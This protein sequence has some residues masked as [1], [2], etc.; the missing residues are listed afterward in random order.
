MDGQTPSYNLRKKLEIEPYVLEPPLRELERLLYKMT[1]EI[2]EET[3]MDKA[4][5]AY[6]G[7]GIGYM[8]DINVTKGTIFY[9]DEN[10]P[11][12]GVI[13]SCEIMGNPVLPNKIICYNEDENMKYEVLNPHLK[14]I[15]ETVKKALSTLYWGIH[16]KLR[17]E[18]YGLNLTPF[19]IE[20][21]EPFMFSRL[22]ANIPLDQQ[23]GNPQVYIIADD[24]DRGM[25]RY[26]SD[27]S[28][29]TLDYL[30]YKLL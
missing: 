6:I 7:M 3:K 12:S 27:K 14:N 15:R 17:E 19:E 30:F 24:E 13:G 29:L 10:R 8:G 11:I 20:S 26:R 9:R 4:N 5:E 22:Y 28:E 2:A 18:L 23:Q 25:I 21:T 16:K 1:S